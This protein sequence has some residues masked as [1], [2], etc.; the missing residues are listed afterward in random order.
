MCIR[1]SGGDPDRPI[2]TGRVYTNLQKTPY[3]LPDNKTQSGWKSNSTGGGGGYN[4]V[5]F[6][7][8]LGKE[9]LRMQAE[10]NMDTLVKNDA[11]TTIIANR[12]SFVGGNN[13]ER[14]NKKETITVTD[15]R[16]V[17]VMANQTHTVAR[18][19]TQTSQE[20]NTTFETRNDWRSHANTH[21]FDSDTK[22]T[23]TVGKTST[24]YITKD[25]IIID[26][27]K[28]LI[29]PGPEALAAAQRGD[30]LP[31]TA[32]EKE[33]QDAAAKE[34]ADKAAAAKNAEAAAEMAPY[35]FMGP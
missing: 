16:S 28:V 33:A 35:M 18:D 3:K 5:M 21:A 22:L 1:D 17:T 10:R 20:G 24:I 2:I 34:A 7:D 14:V 9:L 4:E 15:D 19:I 30:P 26:S 11:S 25:Y 13:T 8:A 23:V 32:S 31:P 12:T 6:E 27:P 29:N